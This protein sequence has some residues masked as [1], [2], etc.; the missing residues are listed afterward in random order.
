[1]TDVQ[2]SRM[3]R[4]ILE[5]DY[6]TLDFERHL[7]HPPE[8][9]WDAITKPEQLAKWY[10]TKARIEGKTGGRIEYVSGPSQ[11]HITGTILA[12]EPPCL[13]EH[14][15]NLEPRAEF[16]KGEHAVIRWELV[17]EGD[18]TL[19]KLTHRHLT[20]GTWTGFAPGTH[21]FL[22]NLQAFLGGT[23]LLNWRERVEELRKSYPPWGY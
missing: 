6:A 5:G 19:L 22:D 10:M 20:R 3:G 4:V 8:V 11:L 14:E 1:M 7:P 13:F 21:A 15:W 2:S 18:G 17:P 23:P 16:T 9:V 12:W